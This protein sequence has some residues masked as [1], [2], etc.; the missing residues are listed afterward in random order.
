MVAVAEQ[1]NGVQFPNGFAFDSV[2]HNINDVGLKVK[3]QTEILQFKKWF[4]KSKVVDE[5]GK[6]MVVYHQ[7]GAD[8][9]V[10]GKYFKK[11]QDVFE[12]FKKDLEGIELNQEQKD[13]YDVVLKQKDKI[14][15]RIND[16]NEL[17]DIFVNFGTRKKVSR[18]LFLFIMPVCGIRLQL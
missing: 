12:Q 2:N 10:D 11:W 15:L 5:Y 13:V 3:P 16:L 1:D 7:T 8:F 18:S 17:E 6:P 9:S 14:R 4:G